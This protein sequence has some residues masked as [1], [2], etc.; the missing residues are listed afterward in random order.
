MVSPA[1]AAS[2][3]VTLHLKI[4]SVREGRVNGT[5]LID[6]KSNGRLVLSPHKYEVIAALMTQPGAAEIKGTADPLPR[7]SG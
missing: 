1:K 6:G 5:V 7:D 2:N 4:T 3:T